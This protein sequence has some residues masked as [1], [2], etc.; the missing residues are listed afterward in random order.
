MWK[1]KIIS[2]ACL[3]S[4]CVGSS[5]PAPFFPSRGDEIPNFTRADNECTCENRTTGMSTEAFDDFVSKINWALKE[6]TPSED[7]AVHSACSSVYHL[8][9][10]DFAILIDI[11]LE[12]PFHV[13]DGVCT[14]L[15]LAALVVCSQSQAIKI[16]DGHADR[17]ELLWQT[18]ALAVGVLD[19]NFHCLDESPLWPFTT[20]QVLDNFLT[21]IQESSNMAGWQWRAFR[22]RLSS[23]HHDHMS[24]SEL[25]RYTRFLIHWVR[26][27]DQETEFWRLRLG[28]HDNFGASNYSYLNNSWTELAPIA[29]KQRLAH[30][31]ET[32][33]ILWSLD[34]VCPFI[35]AGVEFDGSR[36]PRVLNSGS[37]PFVPTSEDC[38]LFGEHHEVRITSSDGLARHYMSLYDDLKI[39]PRTMPVQC[40]VEELSRCFPVNYFDVVHMKN[41]LDHSFDP[42]EGIKQMLHVLRPGGWIMLRHARNEGVDGGFR[43]GLH[44]WAFDA[45]QEGAYQVRDPPDSMCNHATR[46]GCV[47]DDPH[48]NPRE[49]HYGDPHFIVEEKFEKYFGYSA[50]CEDFFCIWTVIF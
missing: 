27:V 42:L 15:V 1:M 8:A 13:K 41:A 50:R 39:N 35:E 49:Y 44:F 2:T 24:K 16:V 21:L 6:R 4:T 43:Y 17:L 19:Y 46:E 18:M 22:N 38:I 30:W 12:R 11:D 26:A 33:E 7:D 37:G 47:S 45:S 40:E 20:S 10:S 5:D 29:E 25:Y 9:Y 14:G 36:A 28:G 48:I 34:S 31:L 32:G 23:N 3:V